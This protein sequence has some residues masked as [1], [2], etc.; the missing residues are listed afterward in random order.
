MKIRSIPEAV[1]AEAICLYETGLSVQSVGDRLGVNRETLRVAFIRNGIDRRGRFDHHGTDEERLR[2]QIGA[3]DRRGCWP[4]LGTINNKGYGMVSLNG[5]GMAAHRAVYMVLTGKPI[6]RELDLCHRCDNPKCVNPDH[7][8]FGTRTDNMRDASA[9]GRMA[10]GMRHPHAI[11]TD[12]QVKEI[13]E[14]VRS[15]EVQRHIAASMG[16][17]FRTLN[18]VATRKSW[19]HLP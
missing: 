5:R 12:G 1:I 2:R 15:G 19:G 14:R 3:E 6:P 8:F 18:A 16:I 11:L 9:K 13:R 10:R 7:M 4:W 17:D